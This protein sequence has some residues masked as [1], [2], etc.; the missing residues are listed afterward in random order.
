M[1]VL[2]IFLS[3]AQTLQIYCASAV[4]KPYSLQ[5]SHKRGK[6]PGAGENE[7]KT[8]MPANPF[9]WEETHKDVFNI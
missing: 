6:D 2:K 8:P 9:L 5:K 3:A 7:I 1:F 4:I